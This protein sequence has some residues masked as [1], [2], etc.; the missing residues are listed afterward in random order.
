MR[1]AD[2]AGAPL[3]AWLRDRPARRAAKW[4]AARPP[5]GAL[6][7]SVPTFVMLFSGSLAIGAVPPRAGQ[8]PALP[9]IVVKPV[10]F[11]IISKYLF[12]TNL[13][14][15]DNAEGA[16]DPATGN[17]Y[18]GFVSAL[19]RLG[20]TA[21]RYPGGTTSDSFDWLRAIG[22]QPGRQPNEPY[23]MQAARLSKV[24]CVLDGP[25]PSD[26]GPDEFGRLLD[27]IGA[28]GT[29]TVNFSTGT[30]QEAADFVAYM[31]AP[32]SKAPSSN[33]AEPSYWAALRARDGHPA[34]YDVPYWEVGNE[35]VFPG[36]YGWRSGQL[37]SIGPHTGPCPP[38]LAPT[39][40]YA[41]GG[42]TAFFL[43]PVGTFAD[44]LPSASYSTGAPGQKVYVYFP[45]AV[46]GSATV[47]VGGQPWSQTSD[48]S[49]AGPGAEVY[50]FS[51]KTGAI[52]F[53]NGGHGEIPPSGAKITVS[54]E[55][56]PHGGFV[57]FYRAM[58]AMGPKIHVCESEETDARFPAGYGAQLPL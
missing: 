19:R 45:P 51:P 6:V 24:C 17:F 37:V 44:Q 55:S 54:Y 9:E 47:Y 1:L 10:D 30:T 23:G 56:G 48:M 34:A 20:V 38:E 33:P 15:A 21:V 53:G 31:T 32:L 42:T 39:C 26:V 52:T 4:G 16:F 18:P 13:L 2:R 43:Q 22:P 49:A 27:Q 46:P 35:Q 5:L 14:W 28:I 25:E 40:L 8:K 11:G 58:K 7:A 29:A 3:R 50:T 57:E 12:G 41:F 36:Q